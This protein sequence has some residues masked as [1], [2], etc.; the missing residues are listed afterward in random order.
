MSSYEAERRYI[1]TIVDARIVEAKTGTAGIEFDLT[2][3]LG[4]IGHQE[5]IKDEAKATKVKSTLVAI[6]VP[7]ETLETREFWAAPGVVLAG[8]QCEIVT[9]ADTYNGQTRVKVQWLNPLRRKAVPPSAALVE[10]IAD[11]FATVPF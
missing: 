5:W 3:D 10:K 2:S 6:G 7:E 1:V 11:L 4:E 9:M 8:K